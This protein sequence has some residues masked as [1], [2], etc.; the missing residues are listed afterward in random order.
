[1]EL[2]AT[3]LVIEDEMI[4]N[5]INLVSNIDDSMSDGCGEEEKE[6]DDCNNTQE[7][8]SEN[9]DINIVQEKKNLIKK[10]NELLKNQKDYFSLKLKV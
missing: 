4:N 1:M 3:L 2:I 6:G 7:D 8:T 10:K 9:K 5:K